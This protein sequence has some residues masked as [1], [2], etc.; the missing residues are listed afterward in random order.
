MV[1]ATYRRIIERKTKMK[2]IIKRAIV[3]MMAVMMFVSF[4]GEVASASYYKYGYYYY[5][6][7]SLWWKKEYKCDVYIDNA[8][9]N[10]IFHGSNAVSTGFEYKGNK[11]A[12]ITISQTRKFSIGSQTVATMNSNIEV[13][14]YGITPSIGGSISKTSAYEWEVSNTIERTIPASAP[15][16]YYS[17]NVL[18]NTKK[19][20]IEGT[21]DGTIYV[22]GISSEPYRSLVYNKKNASYSGCKRY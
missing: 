8:K 19:I 6:K 15:I 1:V 4:G 11:N 16:G 18:I 9:Y 12:P 5:T 17:Y 3:A 14:A 10:T 7:G 21:H 22:Y 20:K 13:S 2:K